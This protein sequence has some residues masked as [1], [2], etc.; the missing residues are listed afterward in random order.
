MLPKSTRWRDVYE[1]LNYRLACSRMNSR[2]G[3]MPNIL[4]PFEVENEWFVLELTPS[5]SGQEM[6]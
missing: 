6:N 5:R 2:K 4:D 3:V 1:W